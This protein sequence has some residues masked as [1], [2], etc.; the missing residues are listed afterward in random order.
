MDLWI[1]RMVQIKLTI[2]LT[3]IV[4]IKDHFLCILINI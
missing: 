2:K 1:K 3:I 4:I